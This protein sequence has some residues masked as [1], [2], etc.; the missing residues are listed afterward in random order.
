MQ[1]R[2]IIGNIAMSIIIIRTQ[3]AYEIAAG[4][5][6]TYKAI[7]QVFNL[8]SSFTIEPAFHWHF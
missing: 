2:L 7:S 8:F 6:M 4:I 5:F 3:A 1:L